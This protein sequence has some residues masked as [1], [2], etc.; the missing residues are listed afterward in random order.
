MKK[1]ASILAVVLLMPAVGTAPAI[2]GETIATVEGRRFRT[3]GAEQHLANPRNVTVQG[4][5]KSPEEAELRALRGAQEFIVM[6]YIV[7]GEE[8]GYSGGYVYYIDLVAP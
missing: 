4:R 5:G 2:A 7:V 1:F 3:L 6:G 8:A